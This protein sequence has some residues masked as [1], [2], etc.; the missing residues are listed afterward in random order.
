M[1]N[2]EKDDTRNPLVTASTVNVLLRKDKSV[3]LL[4]ILVN[5]KHQNC[6]S[7]MKTKTIN[8]HQCYTNN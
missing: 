2:K 4:L 8:L 1:L 7:N 5:K 3:I 6:R